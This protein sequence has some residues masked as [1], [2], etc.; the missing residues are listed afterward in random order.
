MLCQYGDGEFIAQTPFGEKIS[1][2]HRALSDK[3][4]PWVEL[5]LPPGIFGGESMRDR[6]HKVLISDMVP[7]SNRLDTW[8]DIVTEFSIRQLQYA[9]DRLAALAGIASEL[10]RVWADEYMF[11][12]WR[13]MLLRTLVWWAHWPGRRLTAAPTWSCD[14]RIAFQRMWRA[15]PIDVDDAHDDDDVAAAV[16]EAAGPSRR[17]VL[18][19][20]LIRPSDGPFPAWMDSESYEVWYDTDEVLDDKGCSFLVVKR[21]TRGWPDSEAFPMGNRRVTTT[22]LVLRRVDDETYARV[23]LAM[24]TQKYR[25]WR[26]PDSRWSELS[27]GPKVRVQLE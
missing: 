15:S 16:K 22:Y 8:K 13:S 4:G 17:L 7:Y 26:D 25:N 18:S 5:R 2:P 27:K 6:L 19:G 24:H 12:L 20:T 10:Q 3:G 21:D 23:G 9:E 11:G 14:S 1:A